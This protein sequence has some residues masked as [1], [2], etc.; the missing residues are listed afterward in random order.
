MVHKADESV[1]ECYVDGVRV[2]HEEVPLAGGIGNNEAPL[3]IGFQQTG[4]T[5]FQGVL[6]EVAF[7]KKA[8]SPEDIQVLF[9]WTGQ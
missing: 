9:Q 5:F 6:D 4:G 1:L 2:R 7:F 8:L 3:Y